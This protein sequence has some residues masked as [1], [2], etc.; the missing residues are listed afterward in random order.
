MSI[1]PLSLLIG[2]LAGGAIIGMYFEIKNM[3][4]TINEIKEDQVKRLPHGTLA[5]LED[6]HA[7][8][9]D[10]NFQNIEVDK[11]IRGLIISEAT[12]K[13]QDDGLRR[14]KE[15]IS[16]IQD[17]PRKYKDRPTRKVKVV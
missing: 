14:I 3:R 1:D 8:I 7:V 17:N 16:D 12:R 9:N 6:I 4:K 2:F 13:Y 5:T 11:V 10:V 15:L